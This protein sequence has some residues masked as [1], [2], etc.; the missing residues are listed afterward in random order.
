MCYKG[1]NGNFDAALIQLISKL[2]DASN[3]FSGE[4]PDVRKFAYSLL[5]DW[6]YTRG[7]DWYT[8][9]NKEESNE[10]S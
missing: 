8:S 7:T 3:Y 5:R 1:S 4:N 2:S 9:T 6:D 10:I